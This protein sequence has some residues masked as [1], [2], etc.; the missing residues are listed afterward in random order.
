MWGP[1]DGF[2]CC[3]VLCVLLDGTQAGVIP[4]KELAERKDMIKTV[5]QSCVHYSQKPQ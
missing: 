4:D 3:Q 1:G 5:P 2:N